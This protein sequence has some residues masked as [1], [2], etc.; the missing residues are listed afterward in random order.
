MEDP[1]LYWPYACFPQDR[2]REP[3]PEW[4]C[5][6]AFA[7][8]MGSGIYDARTRLLQALALD[9]A[10]GLR[11]FSSGNTLLATPELAASSEAVLGFGRPGSDWIDTRVFQYPG[12]GAV[13]LHNDVPSDSGLEPN[14]HFLPYTSES[15]ESVAAVLAEHRRQR[16]AVRLQMRLRAFDH[17]QVHHSYTARV[18]SVLDALDLDPAR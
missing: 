18:T 9:T 6:L 7:G 13:L 3:C 11:V 2:I 5:R 8:Q 14:I 4:A 12:A 17:G 1:T 10:V 16:E 15:P